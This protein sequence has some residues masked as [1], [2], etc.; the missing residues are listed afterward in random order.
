MRPTPQ[1]LF[2]DLD[3]IS[4]HAPRVGCDPDAFNNR[5][6]VW[7]FQSTHPVWGATRAAKTS[8]SISII[9][10]IH[11]PRVGCDLVQV[12]RT[13]GIE[14]FQSTHPV[15]GAT[16][17]HFACCR[18]C[19][20]FNPRTPCGVRRRG[21]L[22][23][24][25]LHLF[26]STHPV[27]GAT[28][29]ISRKRNANRDFNPR[30]P[31]G[32]RPPSLPARCT[33]LCDFNPRTPCGVRQGSALQTLPPGSNFNPRTPCGVRQPFIAPRLHQYQISIHAPRVGCDHGRH[34]P[35]QLADEFQSTHPVWGATWYEPQPP[36]WWKNFNPRTPCGVRLC[37]TTPPQIKPVDFNPRTPCGVRP[38]IIPWTRPAKNISIHAPRV[39]CDVQLERT[40]RFA[41]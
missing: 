27:W 15:W 34:S 7:Q 23:M 20:Y 21:S 31:C 22:P 29:S 5:N 6:S 4:I 33:S 18:S 10:S 9:I 25:Q 40:E 13:W 8:S 32:V 1:W 16:R 3:R 30:T 39:G 36:G 2:D 24:Q 38:A 14:L 41:M 11:A 17:P 37:I 26:Q 28:Q 19:R 12:P 35:I